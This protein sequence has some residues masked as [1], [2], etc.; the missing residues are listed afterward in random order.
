MTF[1]RFAEFGQGREHPGD[2]LRRGQTIA[3]NE[4]NAGH[5][6]AV[7]D[8]EF[9][10]VVVLRHEDAVFVESSSSYLWIGEACARA[11]YERQVVA[12]VGERRRD[13]ADDALVYQEPDS[14]SAACDGRLAL[15]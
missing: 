7:A 9:S 5:D 8:R 1:Q 3:A 11:S 14:H 4:E 2:T 10:K 15:R 12:S 6:D 13:R